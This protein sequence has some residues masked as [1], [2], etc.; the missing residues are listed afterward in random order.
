MLEKQPHR[1]HYKIICASVTRSVDETDAVKLQNALLWQNMHHCEFNVT[2]VPQQ[3]EIKLQWRDFVFLFL[4]FPRVNDEAGK[5]IK[6]Q[7][8]YPAVQI[9]PKLLDCSW[10]TSSEKS[11]GVPEK[12]LWKTNKH[13][14]GS[15]I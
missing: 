3:Q 5:K 12:W 2:S 13:S 15:I 11:G 7:S 8:D 1:Q 9:F 14:I 4:F 6:A 10:I